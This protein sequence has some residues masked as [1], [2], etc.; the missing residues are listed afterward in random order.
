MSGSDAVDSD[1]DP[2]YE[3]TLISDQGFRTPCPSNQQVAVPV[4][5][6]P[7]RRFTVL[8]NRSWPI[9]DWAGAAGRHSIERVARKSR[10]PGFNH[11][12]DRLKRHQ[13]VAGLLRNSVVLCCASS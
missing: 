1:Q 3:P 7:A 9:I 11:Q 10:P 4:G 12:L 2:T 8:W 6:Q 13:E 5:V